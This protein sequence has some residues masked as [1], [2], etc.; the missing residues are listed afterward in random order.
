MGRPLGVRRA[1]VE[2]L[3]PAVLL[4]KMHQRVDRSRIP[5][6]RTTIEFD[7][8]GKRGPGCGCADAAEVSV[9]LNPPGF[10]TDLRCEPTSLSFIGCGWERLSTADARRCGAVSVDG[11]P[12]LVSQLPRWFTWSPMAP[13]VRAERERRRGKPGRRPS[14]EAT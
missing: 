4:W 10:D 2:E 7:F 9:C 13:Y 3:D 6:G 11:P 14:K 1:K 5:P 8:T 12:A